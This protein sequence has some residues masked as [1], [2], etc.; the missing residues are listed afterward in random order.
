M[1]TIG[2]NTIC[3]AVGELYF[4]INIDIAC[5]SNYLEMPSS[6]YIEISC[7]PYLL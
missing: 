5:F 2:I 6:G 1:D 3:I 4:S 7:R